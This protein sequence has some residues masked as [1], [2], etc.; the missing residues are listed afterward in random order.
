MTVATEY[1]IIKLSFN[2]LYFKLSF[3]GPKNVVFSKKKSKEASPEDDAKRRRWQN[4]SK[5]EIFKNVIMLQVFENSQTVKF[6]YLFR[7]RRK[8]T[9]AYFIAKHTVQQ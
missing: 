8:L 9:L 3:S 1:S 5:I 4:S 6:E 7:K 2:Y